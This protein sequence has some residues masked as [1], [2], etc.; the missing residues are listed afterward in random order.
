[1]FRNQLTLARI[2]CA[3]GLTAIA[4]S[5]GWSE[6]KEASGKD[7][8]CVFSLPFDGNT[9]NRQRGGFTIIDVDLDVPE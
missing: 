1:M 8:P 3:L 6:L 9:I 4:A 5:I 7:R 2:L